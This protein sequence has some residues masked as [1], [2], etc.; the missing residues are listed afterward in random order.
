MFNV[1]FENFTFQTSK[2]PEPKSLPANDLRSGIS[3]GISNNPI[4]G[5]FRGL[6][7]FVPTTIVTSNTSAPGTVAE[8][9][10]VVLNGFLS[11]LE[12]LHKVCWEPK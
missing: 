2:N 6:L 10:S 4:L 8:V 1:S 7:S 5:V 12:H 9:T 11:A 3:L